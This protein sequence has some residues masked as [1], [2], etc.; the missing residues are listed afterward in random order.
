MAMK[1]W[2]IRV[3]DWQW[4]AADRGARLRAL[5][6]ELVWFYA[7]VGGSGRRWHAQCTRSRHPGLGVLCY[8][9]VARFAP[10]R[11]F[12]HDVIQGTQ[13][14]T[15]HLHAEP[16]RTIERRCAA[17]SDRRFCQLPVRMRTTCSTEVT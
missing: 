1:A 2:H 7:G 11:Q 12:W 16:A 15:Q 10:S 13:L 14:V 4:A 17:T 5:S 6:R 3:L 8:A 9:A